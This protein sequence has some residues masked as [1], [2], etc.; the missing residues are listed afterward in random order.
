MVVSR[1]FRI[2]SI[3]VVALVVVVGL[4]RLAAQVAPEPLPDGCL[5]ADGGATYDVPSV[6]SVTSGGVQTMESD[7]CVNGRV[8]QEFSCTVEG[9]MDRT[10]IDCPGG[11]LEGAC[12]DPARFSCDDSDGGS[13]YGSAGTVSGI[14]NGEAYSFTDSC[15]D[16][17]HLSEYR[18]EGPQAVSETPDDAGIECPGGCLD[19]ACIAEVAEFSCYDNDG[20]ENPDQRGEVQGTDHYQNFIYP[21]E[22]IDDHWLKE[23]YCDGDIARQS[24]PETFGV[25]CPAGCLDGACIHGPEFS[26]VD[27]DGGEDLGVQGTVSGYWRNAAYAFTESCIDETHVSEFRCNDTIAEAVVPDVGVECPNGCEEGRC[28]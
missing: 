19:G 17:T 14:W 5:D 9:T 4:S 23:F 6:V 16:G 3:I 24:F 13:V 1:T 28:L 12:A 10:F 7:S 20:G 21:E 11:C 26:C 22:C 2:G 18:C 8:L 15:K 27:S 25:Y